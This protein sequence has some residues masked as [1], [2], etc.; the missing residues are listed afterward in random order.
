MRQFRCERDQLQMLHRHHALECLSA[1][2]EI[3]LRMRTET[4]R[5]DERAL[6]MHPENPGAREIILLL[7]QNGF[8]DRA[9]NFFD[10][11]N[12]RSHRSWQP[13]RS[14]FARKPLRNLD[15]ATRR[16]VHHI[17]A[18][19]AM[20]LQIDEAGKNVVRRRSRG[21]LQRRNGVVETDYPRGHRAVGEHDSSGELS[22]QTGSILVGAVSRREQAR[23]TRHIEEVDGIFFA[24]KHRNRGALQCE[25][26]LP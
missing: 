16:G 12:R 15:D 9:M 3:K 17:N 25:D 21:G 4:H 18:V 1:R 14:A 26:V 2:L 11:I 23:K 20:N 10:A 5:R 8:A 7:A 13:C 24:G 22:H 6:Q 19:R